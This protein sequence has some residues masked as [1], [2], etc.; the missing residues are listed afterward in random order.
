MKVLYL[1]TE[2]PASIGVRNK[3]LSKISALNNIGIEA[4]CVFFSEAEIP[5]KLNALAEHILYKPRPLPFIFNKRFIWKYQIA[6]RNFFFYRTFYNRIKDKLQ[7]DYVILRYPGADISLYRFIKK[8][9]VKVVL[10]HNS[11]ELEELKLNP[12]LFL[13]D[14]Y[15]KSEQNVGPRILRN[16]AGLIAVTDEIRQY[17]VERSGIKKKSAVISNGF[18][19]NSVV[20]RN[21]PV[22]NGTEVKI[23]YL[24]GS[25]TSDWYGIDRL[26]K[27]IAAYNGKI[28]FSLYI[29]GSK[30]RKEMELASELSITDKVN[31][32][33][34]AEG[35][36]LNK[37]FND[38]HI[39]VAALAMFR[40]GLEQAAALKVKEYLSRG[41]P[42]MLGYN[43]VDLMNNK[44]ADAFYLQVENNESIIELEKITDFLTKFY[45]KNENPN[46]M[47]DFAFKSIDYSI[48]AREYKE[49][50]EGL[51]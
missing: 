13:Y 33:G 29:A 7:V 31:F 30:F 28:N 42:F 36:E 21:S 9:G 32:I 5:Q 16:V 3:I 12:N 48:K 6:Y 37:L 24:I 38:C 39:A 35:E 15:Y 18:N 25:G 4:K 49:F 2:S 8:L 11:K 46:A 40:I 22:Y 51:N 14:Y 26:M 34:Y 10:E 47:R 1:T 19:V 43:E 45:A 41:M 23:L 50:L 27:S 20:I 17:E 44:A